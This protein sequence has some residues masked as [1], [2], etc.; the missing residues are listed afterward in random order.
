VGGGVVG[1]RDGWG[2]QQSGEEEAQDFDAAFYDS[3]PK[4]GMLVILER[5]FFPMVMW[6]GH[7]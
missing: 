3:S 4:P 5:T 7:C 2:C 1:V 6:S